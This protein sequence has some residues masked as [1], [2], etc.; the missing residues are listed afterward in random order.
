VTAVG[1]PVG[2]VTIV[3]S[4]P[5]ARVSNRGL[6]DRLGRGEPGELSGHRIQRRGLA[7]A[8]LGGGR[9][10]AHPLGEPAD[11][12]PGAEQHHERDDVMQV[13]H[14]EREVGR[15]EKHVEGRD[16]RDRGDDAARP[17]NPGGRDDHRQELHQRL[18][19]DV[20][21]V[22]HQPTCEGGRRDRQQRGRHVASHGGS[23]HRASIGPP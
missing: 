1:R 2:P 3:A 7:L 16:R 12:Q 15:N 14:R 6:G 10:G 19:G 21:Y 22:S 23:V 17:P 4:R 11:H 8:A 20:E 5:S 9:L 18:I 13:G